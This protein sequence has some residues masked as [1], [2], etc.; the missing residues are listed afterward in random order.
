MSPMDKRNSSDHNPNSESENENKQT[1]KTKTIIYLII[2]T[3]IFGSLIASGVTFLLLKGT[4]ITSKVP[5]PLPTSSSSPSTETPLL[6]PTSPTPTQEPSTET[7][8]PAPISPTPTQKPNVD[9][10]PT[11]EVQNPNSNNIG[12]LKK[13]RV[14]NDRI[15]FNNQEKYYFFSVDSPS[16]VSLYLDKVTNGI[17]L[18]LYVDTNGNGVVDSN[19]NM[20]GDNAYSSRAGVINQTLGADKYIAVVKFKDGNSDYNLQLVND[21][22]DAVDVGLLKGTKNFS[23]AINRNS[24]MKY[25]KFNLSSPSNV[26]FYLDRVTNEVGMALYVDKNG[27]GVIDY[28]EKLASDNGYSSRPGKI[29]QALGADSYFVVI[30]EKG[31]NTNY[32]LTMS[33]P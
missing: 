6:I 33:S 26:S 12:V 28:N 29:S 11:T 21:T 24:R 10:K 7:P 2:A 18:T 31:E 30:Y 25:Y 3:F 19:E 8:S 20:A 4:D 9:P 14:F 27:N 5:T 13:T 16:N 17:S 1:G 23:G 32:S 15:S 22:N